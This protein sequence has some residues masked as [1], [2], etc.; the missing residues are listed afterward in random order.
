MPIAIAA[1]YYQVPGKVDVLVAFPSVYTNLF[2]LGES[3]NGIQVR[4]TPYIGRVTGDRYGGNEGPAVENQFFGWTAD[5]QLDLSRYDPAQVLKIENFGGLI[6]TNGLVALDAVGAFL[7]RDRG[8]RVLLYCNRTPALSINFPCAMLSGPQEQ[9]KG[10]KYSKCGFS[11]TAN[12]APEGYWNSASAGIVW[13]A[14][15]TGITA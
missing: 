9:G 2:K 1:D 4:K 5:C 7:Q 8:I 13:D 3:E 11:M 15:T 10:T 14:D 12:R 6:T